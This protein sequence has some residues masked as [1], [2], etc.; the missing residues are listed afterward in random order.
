M[1]QAADHETRPRN[2]KQWEIDAF[3]SQTQYLKEYIEELEKEIE[4]LRTIRNEQTNTIRILKNKN[5]LLLTDYN[6]LFNDV[7]EVFHNHKVE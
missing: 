6:S 4:E 5:T 2:A 1:S 7:S 3:I